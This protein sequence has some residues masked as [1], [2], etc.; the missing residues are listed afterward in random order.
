MTRKERERLEEDKN[1]KKSS[2]A[3]SRPLSPTHKRHI[4]VH[5]GKLTFFRL[6]VTKWI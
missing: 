4:S 1:L 6:I 2:Y 5:V 3:T